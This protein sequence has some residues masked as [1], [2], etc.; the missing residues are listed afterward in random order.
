MVV[1]V[2]KQDK[3]S[4]FISSSLKIVKEGIHD[5]MH[6]HVVTLKAYQNFFKLY[7]FLVNG[8]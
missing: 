2:K 1:L 4:I 3:H 7:A 5:L 6:Y 8:F